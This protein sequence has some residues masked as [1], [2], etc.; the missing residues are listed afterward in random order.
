MKGAGGGGGEV[1]GTTPGSLKIMTCTLGM[2]AQFMAVAGLWQLGWE[3]GWEGGP[4]RGGTY[5]LL[6]VPGVG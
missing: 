3:R 4:G 2:S 5:F 1:G 6:S